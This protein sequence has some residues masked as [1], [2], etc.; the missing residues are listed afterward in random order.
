MDVDIDGITVIFPYKPYGI[1][2]DYM[3][4]VIQA[5]Q[6]VCRSHSLVLIQVVTISS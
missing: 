2:V 3:R 4:S 5:L 1:Q 6:K